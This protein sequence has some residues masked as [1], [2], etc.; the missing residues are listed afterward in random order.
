LKLNNL[1]W[2]DTMPVEKVLEL[3]K[4]QFGFFAFEGAAKEILSLMKH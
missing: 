1:T 2:D 3:T 4:N